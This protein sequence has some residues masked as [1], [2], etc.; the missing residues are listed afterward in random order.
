MHYILLAA[1]LFCIGLIGTIVSRHFMRILISIEFM[2]NAVNINLVAFANYGDLS[3]LDGHI[4]S[5]FVMAIA[6]CE[7]AVGLAFL[8][9][10]FRQTKSVDA[11]AVEVEVKKWN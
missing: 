9:L 6:V 1:V 5:L 3:K 4:M 10:V 2:L 7:L 8:L 11:D